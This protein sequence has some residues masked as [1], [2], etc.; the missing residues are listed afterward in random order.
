VDDAL[1]AAAGRTSPMPVRDTLVREPG[2]RYID[3][4]IPGLIGLNVLNGGL[5][6]VGFHLVDMR[7][8]KLI[9]RL[10]ATP[11]R[12]PDFLAAQ[13]LHRLALMLVEV[14]FLLGFGRL[15][16]GVPVRGSWLAIAAA[17]VV[18]ALSASSIGLLLGSRASRIESVIGLMNVVSLPMMIGSGV[19]FSVERFPEWL[20][21]LL[22]ALPLTALIDALRALVLEGAPLAA[23][24]ERLL[25]VAGWGAAS[26]V[27]GYR[28]FKWS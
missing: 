2:S 16:L 3:F 24:G 19:F 21:P 17:C 20:Q 5:W 23:Q 18:G 15:A 27:L 8:K 14:A 10:L 12:R 7:M 25:L 4:L 28:L 26:F 22:R 13:F 9:K 1:Q 6:G 11:M